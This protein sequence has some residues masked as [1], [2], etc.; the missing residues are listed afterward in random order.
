MG[1]YHVGI[2]SGNLEELARF[3]NMLLF[4]DSVSSWALILCIVDLSN[5]GIGEVEKRS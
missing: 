1:A 5:S 2:F 4:P 3:D